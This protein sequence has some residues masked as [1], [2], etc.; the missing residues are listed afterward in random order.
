MPHLQEI[1]QAI[2][3]N[4]RVD[5]HELEALRLQVYAGGRI[6]ARWPTFSSN[7]TSGFNT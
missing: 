4:G 6:E 7:C 2:L 3:A 5:G 1:E